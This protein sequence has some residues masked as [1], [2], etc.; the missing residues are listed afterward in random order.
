MKMKNTLKLELRKAFFNKFFFI[1]LIIL[2]I[3]CILSLLYNVDIFNKDIENMN[4]MGKIMNTKYNP[5]LGGGTIFNFWI[6]NEARSLGS[7]IF[8]YIFPLVVAIPYGWSYCSE[9]KCGYVKNMVIRC[10]R[11]NY[12]LSKYIAT[13]LSGGL[14]M[15]IPLI[16]NIMLIAC[17]IPARIPDVVSAVYT[18]I[19][20]E[21]LMAELYYS[22]PFLYLAFYLLIDF[23]FCGLIATLSFA[24]TTFTKSRVVVTLFP[25]AIILGFHYFFGAFAFDLG[26]ELSPLNFLKPLCWEFPATWEV[27]LIEG[28]ILFLITFSLTFLKGRKKEIY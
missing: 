9:L 10:G 27:I 23:F 11:K 20:P 16:I 7:T 13:F 15:I 26:K 22:K 5:D 17:F 19:F 4:R 28:G 3:P 24:I 8:F 1:A 18:G 21:D 2:I 6:G 12:Y 25:F 14:V